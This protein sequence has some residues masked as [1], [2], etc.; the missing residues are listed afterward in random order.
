[1]PLGSLSLSLIAALTVLEPTTTRV[2]QAL[3]TIVSEPQSGLEHRIC[4]V[5]D[6]EGRITEMIRRGAFGETVTSAD[7]LIRGRVALAGGGALWASCPGCDAQR[8]GRL[9]LEYLHNGVTGRYVSRALR[10]EQFE[11]SFRLASEQGH[12]I[13][14]LRLTA[15]RLFGALI[16]IGDL[17]PE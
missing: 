11:G 15:R 6:A 12:T 7:D 5:L 14:R 13:R 2:E 9:R 10:L 4:L 17:V 16:G 8:G 3:V 1:M